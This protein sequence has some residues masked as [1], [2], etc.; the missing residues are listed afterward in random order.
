MLDVS[1]WEIS[2][3]EWMGDQEKQWLLEPQERGD[4]A[5]TR[6]LFKPSRL[7]EY[8]GKAHGS[9]T[10]FTWYDAQSE[11]IAHELA[12]LIGVPTA[13]IRLA[14]RGDRWGCISKDVRARSEDLQ[15]GDVFLAGIP[16]LHYVPNVERPSNRT[17]HD[18]DSIGQVLEGVDPPES[19]DG[20]TA[21]QVF[22]G[23]LV[24]DAWIGNTDR[25]AENWAV[26]LGM[27]SGRLAP[28]FDH[29]SSLASGRDDRFLSGADPLKFSRGAMARK[30]DQGKNVRLVDLALGAVARWGGPW[31]TRLGLV[32][33]ARVHDIVDTAPRMSD[34]R[35]TFL[36]R[37]LDEN[38]RRMIGTWPR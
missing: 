8:P 35:R 17:G 13:S 25:H 20:V 14:R 28:S 1:N 33:D 5:E 9:S 34:L 18:L 27:S 7:T 23:Y 3:D 38:R 26:L 2:G 21:L 37:M 12:T 29:G 16:D 36:H 10:T 22:A 19:G 15:S 30:F 32:D 11:H 24:L 6:W 4:R 31:T